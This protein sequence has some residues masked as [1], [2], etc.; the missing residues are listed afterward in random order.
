MGNY[1]AVGVDIESIDRFEKLKGEGNP[2]LKKIFT[3]EELK[4]CL[5]KKHP[6][7]HL[8]AR[9]AGKEAVIKAVNSLNKDIDFRDIEITNN[10]RGVPSVELKK[11]KLAGYKV[12]ISLSHCVDKAVAFCI[13][14]KND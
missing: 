5:G 13:I 1:L 9:F 14:E 11:K 12:L 8:T 10:E 4:Y 3:P 7:K 6:S 2:V